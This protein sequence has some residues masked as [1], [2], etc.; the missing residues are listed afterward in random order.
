[1]QGIETPVHENQ[2][3]REG[4]RR[5]A[6]EGFFYEIRNPFEQFHCLPLLSGKFIKMKK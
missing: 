4:D 6:V 2:F 5:K 1:V 3:S